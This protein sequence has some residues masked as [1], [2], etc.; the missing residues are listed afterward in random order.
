LGDE[1]PNEINSEIE[2]QNTN[3]HKGIVKARNEY[4]NIHKK[5]FID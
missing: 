2:V 1:V 3:H 4:Y 5:R